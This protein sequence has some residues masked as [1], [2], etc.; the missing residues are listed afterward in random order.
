MPLSTATPMGTSPSSADGVAV[1]K[2]VIQNEKPLD[3]AEAISQGMQLTATGDFSG[4]LELFEMALT[5]PGSGTLRD[6]K[7]ARELS[8]VNVDGYKVVLWFIQ[9][10]LEYYTLRSKTLFNQPAGKN[11]PST[12]LKLCTCF[13]GIIDVDITAKSGSG[14]VRLGDARNGL[15]ALAGSLE[16]GFDDFNTARADPDLAAL[17]ENPQFEGLMMRFQPQ[18]KGGISGFFDKLGF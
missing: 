13:P 7:K 18:K 10:T 16:V 1:F 6:R 8:E 15:V 4:A 5:L 14:T 11:L 2:A 17:R 3:A 9:R 12:R